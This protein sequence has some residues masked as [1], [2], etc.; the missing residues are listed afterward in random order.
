MVEVVGTS[1]T[2][3]SDAIRGAVERAS[4]TLDDVQ[5]FEV[6]EIRGRVDDGEVA[7]YQVKLDISFKLRVPERET[8]E[9]GSSRQDKRRPTASRATRSA[10]AQIAAKRGQ[11]GRSELSRGFEHQPGR[12]RPRA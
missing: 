10:K 1:G 7:E 8:G 4:Q 5:W 11:R 2:S 3:V 6:K 12:A 9:T